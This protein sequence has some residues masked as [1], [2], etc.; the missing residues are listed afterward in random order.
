MTRFATFAGERCARRFDSY[1][2]LYRWSVDDIPAFWAAAWDFLGIQASAPYT[3]AVDDLSRFPG[4]AWFPGA[5]LNMAQNLLRHRDDGVALAFVG[6]T[7]APVRLTYA[8]LHRS[9][10]RVAGALRAAG[11]V[12]G[13]RVAGYLPNL[14]ETVVAMLAATSIGAVWSSCAT[15]VGPAA[16]TDRLG[17]IEPKVLFAVD[18]Y[19]YKD[20]VFDCIPGAAALTRS[21]P[22]LER[23][24]VAHYAGDP[25]ADLSSIRGAVRWDE[26]VAGQSGEDLSFEQ[27]PF[28]H[29]AVVMFSSGTTGKP[30]CLVQSG[31]GI[32]INQLK[33]LVL[34][35]DVTRD[36]TI[37]YVTTAS[38]MMWNWLVSA[39]GTGA[40]VVLFD[41][42]PAYP[43]LG[44]LWRLI[45]D[46]KVTVFGTSA[47]YLNLLRAKGV[48]PGED[49]DLSALREICQTGSVLSPEGFTYVYEAI[50]SDLHF[51]SLSGGTDINGCFAIGSPTLPVY[52]GQLQAPGLGMKIEC[53]DGEGRPI[54]DEVGELVCEAPAPPMPLYFWDDPGGERYHAAYF[55]VY[56]GVWRHGDY[57]RFDST[58]GG[59]TFFGR[60]DAVLKP[61]GVRIGTA[62][63]YNQVE[64]LP[65]IADSLAI[66]Q[67]WQGDQRIVLFVKLVDGQELTDELI[68]KIARTLRE[69]ASPRHVPAKVVAVPDIPYTLNMKKVETS[70]ANLL[71]GRAVT[72]RDALSNPECLDFYEQLV[73]V[74]SEA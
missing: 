15:D 3:A 45:E 50:K 73:P 51:N 4:A 44:A 18:G 42:N 35:A 38:W 62:E 47:S 37:F 67:D 49:H 60:S 31:G 36:D 57:V 58:T 26:F 23:V 9:V 24:V 64:K 25:D 43:D 16:A 11:V 21:I 29:P 8:E 63:I 53:Y 12:P 22:S 52:A 5:R 14:V 56:P 71:H 10:A 30:K 20:R 66:G 2:E 6:E 72:N 39:L 34:H 13:D 19:R 69:N 41:G 46:L 32:L 70:V 27:V 55:D 61:S 65:E 7:A 48:A 74:L 68:A 28:D 1:E 17:Q 59:V 40:T 54:R 33:E